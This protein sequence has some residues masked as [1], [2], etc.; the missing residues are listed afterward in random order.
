MELDIKILNHGSA[1][2]VDDLQCPECLADITH[3]VVEP[4]LEMLEATD[5]EVQTG[6][7]CTCNWCSCMW[8]VTAPL[9][10]ALK[11]L[12]IEDTDIDV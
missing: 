5:D 12:P 4:W 11:Q 10:Q 9:D 2:Y 8:L 3:I 1:F 6:I 7:R